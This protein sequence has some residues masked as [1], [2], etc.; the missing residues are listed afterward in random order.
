MSATAIVA[1]TGAISTPLVAIAGYVFNERRSRAD[2]AAT[3]ELTTEGHG[4][5]RQLA[6]GQ[7]EHEAQLRRDERQYEDRRDACLDL[8]R[9]VLLFVEHVRRVQ[10][11]PEPPSPEDWRDLQARVAAFGSESLNAAADRFYNMVRAF[12][13]AVAD[14]RLARDPPAGDDVVAASERMTSAREEVHVAFDDLRRLIRE[15]LES[16]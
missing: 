12:N 13:S 11:P 14:Y 15:E 4:H 6:E 8:L 10:I 9:A 3:R 2:R 7:R 5:E 16:L 1:V